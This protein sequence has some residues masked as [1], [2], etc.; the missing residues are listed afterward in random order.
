M[1][2]YKG[3]ACISRPFAHWLEHQA[4]VWFASS[5]LPTRLA[6]CRLCFSRQGRT[7]PTY[8]STDCQSDRS[9]GLSLQGR[10][11]KETKTQS[12]PGKRGL[13]GKNSVYSVVSRAGGEKLARA[14]LGRSVGGRVGVGAVAV[15]RLTLV[16][17]DR[18]RP[19]KSWGRQI[20]DRRSRRL[21]VAVRTPYCEQ[22]T[23]HR[24]QQV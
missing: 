24:K 23:Y 18:D 14:A 3:Q 5:P 13:Y 10:G 7:R 15:P 16:A 17:A 9:S 1:A 11:H 4:P 2:F 22:W 6:R 19:A 20:A 8:V 21:N 12:E